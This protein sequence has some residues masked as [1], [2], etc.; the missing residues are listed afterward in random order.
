MINII[1][2]IY[3]DEILI[4]SN[5]SSEHKTHVW[6]VLCRL[7]ANG[8]ITCTDKCEFHVTSCNTLDICCHLKAS[9][10]PCTKSRLSKIG[11][12][13][14]KSRTFN[15]S[16][17]SPTSTVISFMDIPKS[18]FCLYVLPTRVPFGTSQISAIQLLKHLKQGFHH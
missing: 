7:H 5:H 14:Q 18:P 10:W 13:P 3:L 12:N 11:L 15:L 16:S 8:L 1:V 6:E 9:P 4:Y 2:I 17:A